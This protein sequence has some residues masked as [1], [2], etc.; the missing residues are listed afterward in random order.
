MREAIG[1]CVVCVAVGVSVVACG[2]GTGEQ[3]LPSPA[4]AATRRFLGERDIAL[5]LAVRGKA[6]DR[7]EEGLRAAAENPRGL[8]AGV[9]ELGSAERRA[10]QGLGVTW[11]NYAWVREE[12]AR[13]LAAQRQRED[14]RI[15]SLE[16]TRTR[17]D[18]AAQLEQA[19]DEAGR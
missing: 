3:A 4:P 8:L 2:G 7:L 15:L 9:E 18:L 17:D 16:L 6:L 5:Y 11:S 13:L 1:R 10:A 19:R 14:A 12:L